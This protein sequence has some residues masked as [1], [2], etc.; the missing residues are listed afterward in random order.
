M[1][2]EIQDIFQCGIKIFTLIELL[3]VIAIVAILASL[4]LPALSKARETSRQIKCAGNMKQL[5]IVFFMYSG[6]YEGWNPCWRWQA[7]LTPYIPGA[8]NYGKLDLGICPASPLIAPTPSPSGVGEGESML[9]HYVYPGIYYDASPSFRYLACYGKYEH[10]KNSQI[11]KPSEKILLMEC[12]WPSVSGVAWGSNRITDRFTLVHFK[13]S[14]FTWIDGHVSKVH[15]LAEK[16]DT[17][18]AATTSWVNN[19]WFLP[20]R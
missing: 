17:I 11:K 19:D 5:G 3:I 10:I 4:L 18:S 12:W 15:V 7:A 9:S 20:L 1:K 6:D 2:R 14:N 13:G 8:P 16:G